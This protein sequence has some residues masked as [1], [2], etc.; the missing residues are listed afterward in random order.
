MTLTFWRKWLLVVAVLFMS[1]A[2]G[3][4]GP[5]SSGQGGTQAKY[6]FLFIGDGMGIAQR[7]S[8]ELYLA[9]LKGRSQPEGSRLVMNTFPAQ[10][11]VT[12]YDLSGVIPDSASTATAIACGYKTRD[13]VIGMDADARVSYVSIAETAKKA[14]WKVGIL[15]TVSLDHATPA[16]FYAH[17]PN[18]SQ[19]Y[20]I[21]LQLANSG[22]DYFAGGQ[23]FQ[24]V[25]PRDSHKPNAI[26]VSRKNGYTVSVGRSALAALRPGIGKVIAMSAAVDSD[27]AMYFSLD[28]SGD[29]NQISIAEY[30]SKGI[31]LLVNPNGFFIMVEAG[32]IDWACHAHDTASSIHDTLALDDAVAIAVDFFKKHP[33]ETLIIVTGDHETGGMA[34][35]VAGT[36]QVSL[37]DIFQHQKM[38]YIEF[39]KKLAGFKRA[40]TLSDARLEDFLPVIQEAFG[41]Y[42]ISSGEKHSLENTAAAGKAKEASEEARKA[43]REAERKLKDGMA[44]S[45]RE[46]AELRNAF[47][48][49]MLAEAERAGDDHSYLLYEG[50]EPL[51]IKLMTIL[52]NKAGI[53]FTTY[54]HTGVPVQTSALGVGAELFNGYYD[55]TDVHAKIMAA[56]G[57]KR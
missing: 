35:G 46:L 40:R 53:G 8:A 51:T 1:C 25:D 27:A 33:R 37:A 32:K 6:V 26:E 56:T 52:N 5:A 54:S 42:V 22:M 23:L 41:L 18:R 10:G 20:D 4:S 49:S 11:L 2:A 44:L 28:Q 15:T 43:A 9:R 57:L 24:P 29:P 55:Q 7:Y 48:Q 3:V 39:N 47:K 19:M 50:Q 34:I 12:T 21:S 17:V 16:A 14:N 31:D 36:Q 13:G 38:S 45:D 30:L